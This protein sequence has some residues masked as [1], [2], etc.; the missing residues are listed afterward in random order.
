M[1]LVAVALAGVVA[2]VAG[3]SFA[4]VAHNR[5]NRVVDECAE[6][7]RRQLATLEGTV[8]NQALRDVAVVHYDA[9]KEMSGR[10]SFSLALLNALGDGVIISSINGRTET[11]TYAK[12]VHGGRSLEVLSP[13][14][15][16]ALRGARLGKGPQ[17]S[18]DDP[19]PDFGGN[20]TS[21]H[22]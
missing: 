18:M 15:D 3:L 21:A 1:I 10:R 20:T 5:V 7:L 17:V 4:M 22:A 2:G 14:E 12:V 19:L 13:E 9:L 6:M 11:R 8:D 16:Q